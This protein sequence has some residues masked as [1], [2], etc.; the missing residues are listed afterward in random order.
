MGIIGAH[1]VAQNEQ[2]YKSR[3]ELQM[4]ECEQNKRYKH[5]KTDTLTY[6]TSTINLL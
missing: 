3:K 6:D 1:I 2:I 5:H 4:T